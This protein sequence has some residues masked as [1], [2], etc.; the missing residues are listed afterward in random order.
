MMQNRQEFSSVVLPDRPLSS[1]GRYRFPPS[2]LA[3]VEL[4]NHDSREKIMHAYREFEKKKE[5][6]LAR[7][8]LDEKALLWFEN[9]EK[10]FNAFDEASSQGNLVSIS[11]QLRSI[12]PSLKMIINEHRGFGKVPQPIRAIL[13]L[14]ALVSGIVASYVKNNSSSG[15]YQTFFKNPSTDTMKKF[16]ELQ[17]AVD[18]VPCLGSAYNY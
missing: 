17:K 1:S 9:V 3:R 10:S 4:V 15:F 8:L 14:I 16:T 5:R 7:Q 2:P 6:L 18:D 12:P 11:E 13:G